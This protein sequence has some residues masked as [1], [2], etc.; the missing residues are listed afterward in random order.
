MRAWFGLLARVVL[1]GTFLVAGGAKVRDLAESV[2]AVHAFQILPYEA[3]K[4]VGAALP[5]VEMALGLLLL[6][7]LATRLAA[8]LS[9]VLQ[10]AFIVGIA[11]AWIRGL[12]IDCGC[13]GGGGQLGAGE[14]PTYFGDIARDVGLLALAV[15]LVWRPRTR[16]AV[17]NLLNPE[18]EDD[19]ET[20]D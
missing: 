1:G 7:G 3:S 11:A 20:E 9:A 2:R 6:V 13:F 10:A 5:F 8:A 18:N 17:D 19:V 4:L 16:L 15:Y 14:S 12:R